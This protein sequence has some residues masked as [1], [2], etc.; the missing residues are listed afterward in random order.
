MTLHPVS[1]VLFLSAL[2]KLESLLNAGVTTS[3]RAEVD[4]TEWRIGSEL[5][6]VSLGKLG[7]SSG[8]LLALEV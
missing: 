5:V 1:Q 3:Y 7:A 4:E 8:Y 6:G 2:R